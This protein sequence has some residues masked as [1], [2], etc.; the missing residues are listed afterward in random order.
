MP[1]EGQ[2]VILAEVYDSKEF[3]GAFE[4]RGEETVLSIYKIS[5]KTSKHLHSLGV[6]HRKKRWRWDGARGNGASAPNI[7][8]RGTSKR[9]EGEARGCAPL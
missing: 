6:L 3:T 2:V 4:S 8:V 5:Q 7:W 9:G 1:G